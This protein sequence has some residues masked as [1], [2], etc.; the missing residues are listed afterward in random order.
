MTEKQKLN[1][2]L[3]DI[4]NNLRGKMEADEFRDYILGFIFYKYLSEKMLRYANKIL[5]PDNMTYHDINLNTKEGQRYLE[6]VKENSIDDL[7]YFLEPGELF[8]TMVMR[9]NGNGKAKF[10][11]GD[12]QKVLID[13]EQSTMGTDSEEDFENLFE[14]LD[15]DSS[16]LGKTPEDRNEL[17][18]KVMEKLDEVDFQLN[19][20][21]SNVLG[22]AYEYL[23][24][25][26]ASG[27]YPSYQL[28]VGFEV[29]RI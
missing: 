13:I 25:Q 29:L 2:K 23:I 12:L 14:D 7:G 1:Q 9:G 8:S 11:I 6:A 10:I 19:N 15:L 4:A 20:P 24:G 27:A 22:D 3:W 28:H 26:F 5:E 21:E 16:K 18:V 17:I